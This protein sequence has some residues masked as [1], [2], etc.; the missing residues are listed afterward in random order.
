MFAAPCACHLQ[1]RRGDRPHPATAF[2]LFLLFSTLH[3]ALLIS[4]AVAIWR[5]YA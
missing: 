3:G 2:R 5:H 4:A 1:R